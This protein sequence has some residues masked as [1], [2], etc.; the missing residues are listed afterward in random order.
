VFWWMRFFS[1]WAGFSSVRNILFSWIFC[2][3]FKNLKKI[4]LTKFF[5]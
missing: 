4:F 3:N 5:P 2:N 1:C